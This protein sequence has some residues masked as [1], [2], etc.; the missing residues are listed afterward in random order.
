M[1]PQNQKKETDTNQK[2]SS[3]RESQNKKPQVVKE[4]TSITSVGKRNE[5]NKNTVTTTK[6]ITTADQA[7]KGKKCNQ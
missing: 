3:R 1:F 7:N 6:T 4:V 2:Q 5:G